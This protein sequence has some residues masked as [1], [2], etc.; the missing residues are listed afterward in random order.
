MGSP[1][2]A[3]ILVL[4][5]TFPRWPNDHIPSFVYELCKRLAAEL[6]VFVLTPHAEG[7]TR[8]EAWDGMMVER[9]PYH[10][11]RRDYLAGQAI[12]P[13]LRK[14]PLLWGLIPSFFVAQFYHC[15]R[16]LKACDIDTVHAHWVLPQGFIAVACKKLF[17][18]DLKVVVTAHGADVYG[19]QA[20]KGLKRWTFE[21]CTAVTAVSSAIRREIIQRIGVSSSSPIHIIPM[22][23]DLDRFSPA[24][25]D[26]SLR[27][28]FHADGPLLLFVGRLTEKK[29]LAYLLRAMPRVL[30]RHPA[31]KLMVIG[32][33]EERSA[34]EQLASELGLFE[35][36]VIF[37]GGMT[38]AELPRYYATADIFVGPSIIAQSGDREGFGLVFVEALGSGCPVITTDLPAMTD[39]V[40]HEKTGLIV[41][42]KDSAALADAIIR[43]L[44]DPDLLARMK[45]SCRNEV[46]AKFHWDV[47]SKRYSELLSK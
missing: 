6:Q 3:K 37:L 40:T 24:H 19:L 43:L 4:T 47:I 26:H 12:L 8:S 42:Q 31:T 5:S 15:I 23:V 2:R 33:G 34:L 21:R 13:E 14:N 36:A 39:I 27:Q 7:S 28:Q 11:G 10:F 16:L 1:D 32:Y 41:P 38:S 20:C 22:G 29:G 46:L 25:Y 44:D 45:S 9:Y 17:K 18:P 35:R 30:D